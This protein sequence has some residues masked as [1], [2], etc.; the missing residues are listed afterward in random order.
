MTQ[1]QFEDLKVKAEA[2]VRD[3]NAKIAKANQKI[4]ELRTLQAQVRKEQQA[5]DAMKRSN[6][7]AQKHIRYAQLR[8]YKLIDEKNLDQSIKKLVEQAG[9]VPNA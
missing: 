1:E 5:V 8:I 7:I 3:V 9:E 6:E 2:V 4:E